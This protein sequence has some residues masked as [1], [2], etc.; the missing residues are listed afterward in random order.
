MVRHS[1]TW[2][3]N[4]RQHNWKD[5]VDGPQDP[6]VHGAENVNNPWTGVRKKSQP[7]IRHGDL[8]IPRRTTRGGNKP[9]GVMG[10]WKCTG[11]QKVRSQSD[12]PWNDE[13]YEWVIY[14]QPVQREFA[15]PLREPWE[16]LSFTQHALQFSMSSLKPKRANEY[17]QMLSNYYL[18]SEEAK[19]ELR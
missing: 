11:M 2:V 17:K 5:C 8:V 4:V 13:V 16:D 3:V 7:D 19:K 1:G 10:I 18:T 12:V 14:C 6:D 9:H 15:E